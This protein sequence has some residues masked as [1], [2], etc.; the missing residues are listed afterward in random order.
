MTVNGDILATHIQYV[1]GA[2][3]AFLPLVAVVSGVF[4]AFAIVNLL[5]FTIVKLVK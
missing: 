4:V 5:R 2:I 1:T 3:E